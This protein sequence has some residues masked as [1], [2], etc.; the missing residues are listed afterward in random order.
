MAIILQQVW[1]IFLLECKGQGYLVSLKIFLHTYWRLLR[2]Y[3]HRG[4]P[5]KLHARQW[6]EGRNQAALQWD[7]HKSDTENTPFLWEEFFSV[8]GKGQWCGLP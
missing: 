4:V 2:D 1:D 3:K 6:T 7:S 5:V 8:V